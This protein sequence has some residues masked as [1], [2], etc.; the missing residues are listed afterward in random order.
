MS[1]SKLFS[2]PLARTLVRRVTRVGGLCSLLAVVG[3]SMAAFNLRGCPV[4]PRCETNANCAEHD[5]G[6]FCTGPAVCAANGRCGQAG[7]PCDAGEIC[8]ETADR[9]DVCANNDDCDDDL[10]C[11]GVETCVAGQCV[12]GTPACPDDGLFCNGTE[13][14][15]EETDTCSSSGNPCDENQ[16]CDEDANV[17]R[18]PC[19]TNADCDDG[20]F[21][22]GEET[23]GDDGFCEDGTDP[24]D[25]ENLCTTDSCNEDTDA[26]THTP[27]TCPSGERCDLETGECVAGCTTNAECNDNN[28]CTTDTCDDGACVNAA[29]TCPQG[30]SCNATTGNCTAI[31]CTSNADCNDGASCSTDTCQLSTGVCVYTLVDAA[32]DDGLFCTGDAVCEPDSDDAE[33]G[34]GCVREGNPCEGEE[35]I[36]VESTDSCRG[37]ETNSECD[38]G[39]PCTEDICEDDGSCSNDP[40]DDECDDGSFCTGEGTCDP[41]DDDADGEGCVYAGDPCAC[42]IVI[43]GLSCEIDASDDTTVDVPNGSRLICNEATDACDKCEA[44]AN[45]DDG[46]ACTTNACNGA[47]GICTNEPNDAL[48]DDD[49]FCTDDDYCDPEHPDAGADGCVHETNP[50]DPQLCDEGDDAAVCV[51]CEAN[52]ECVGFDGEDD[53][54]C[55]ETRCN[56]ATGECVNTPVDANC[57]E[58]EICDPDAKGADEDGCV[59]D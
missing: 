50:C 25:D 59:E 2:D 21:C 20:L 55:T 40:D 51:E 8:N 33:A 48:C 17:C 32:C 47:T 42:V 46:V 13:S 35:P 22:N 29:V 49:L 10:F 54:D 43:A 37:C 44:N 23:C 15:N 11:N 27:V 30:Q 16:G 28:A 24:C 52:A 18:D 45:C 12:A 7:N 1:N 14:C 53:F 41:E 9:C 19:D 26:C 31:V 56:G 58:G 57:G 39:V 38:D 5:D 3:L 4:G 34:T 36:C 6:L